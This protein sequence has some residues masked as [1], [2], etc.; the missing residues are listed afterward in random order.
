MHLKTDARSIPYEPHHEKT[1]YLH[2]RKQRCR[3][4]AQLIS[5]FVLATQLV[6]SLFFL[7]PKFPASSHFLCVSDL[8][9]IPEDRISHIVAHT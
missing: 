8:V 7:N 2:M 3:S 6:Q 5:A 1:C 9:G 4:A